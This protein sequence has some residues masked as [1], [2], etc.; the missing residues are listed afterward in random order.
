MW[1]YW[2]YHLRFSHFKKKCKIGQKSDFKKINFSHFSNV[3][4]LVN[5]LPSK[6]KVAKNHKLFFYFALIFY[7]WFL[8]FFV[9]KIKVGDSN[10]VRFWERWVDIENTFGDLATFTKMKKMQD[11]KN[12]DFENSINSGHGFSGGFLLYIPPF[13][14]HLDFWKSWFNPHSS[15]FTFE[16][17]VSN[18][19]TD[20][21]L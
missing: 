13:N 11:G 10:F 9:Y 12:P 6:L 7:L 21:Q 4:F 14:L 1:R 19:N 17:Q 18:S 5:I 16:F 20:W 2:K 3:I 15:H 8:D